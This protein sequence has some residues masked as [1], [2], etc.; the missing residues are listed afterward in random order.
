MRNAVKCDEGEPTCL[1]CRSTG[2]PCDGD[3]AVQARNPAL[4]THEQSPTPLD[5]PLRHPSPDCS[6]LTALQ[7][8][9]TRTIPQ[10]SSTYPAASV[11]PASP[12]A[13]LPVHIRQ[14]QQRACVSPGRS[15]SKKVCY[16]CQQIIHLTSR[17]ILGIVLA[18]QPPRSGPSV[19]RYSSSNLWEKGK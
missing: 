15:R 3:D 9:Q 16:G 19:W 8:F 18:P 2:R 17:N 1:K 6:E 7:F 5:S 11:S 4:Q 12:T 10:L 14:E 13:S